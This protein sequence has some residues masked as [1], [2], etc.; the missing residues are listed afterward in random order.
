M[1]MIKIYQLILVWISFVPFSVQG[2][3]IQ[4]S[5]FWKISGNGLEKP[6]YIFGTHH[7]HDYAFIEKNE[8]IHKILASVDMVVGEVVVND[9]NMAGIMAKLFSSM[10]M[11]DQT[12]EKLLTPEQFKKVDASLR[13]SS[14]FGLKFFN[15]YKPIFVYLIIMASK[16]EAPIGNSMDIYFQQV[17]QK[18]QKEIKGLETADEQLSVLANGYSLERQV[19]MLMEI[20]DEQEGSESDQLKELGNLYRQQNI[21]ALYTLMQET[22]PEDELKI[23]LI[24]RNIKWIPQIKEIFAAQK[25]AFIAVGAGHLPGDYGVLNLLAQKGYTLTPILIPVE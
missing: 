7:L 6:S 1:K 12:L 9:Q 8:E 10:M 19:E 5:I 20:V 11:K 23:L 3:T 13:T 16:M 18:T 25:S 17:G 24:D 4:N 15:N 14:G 22:S 2:Q 21:Q